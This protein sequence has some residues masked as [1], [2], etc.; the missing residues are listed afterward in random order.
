MNQDLVQPI[1][2]GPLGFQGL[3]TSVPRTILFGEG[4]AILGKSSFRFLLLPEPFP[5]ALPLNLSYQTLR[6]KYLYRI[7]VNTCEFTSWLCNFFSAYPLVHLLAICLFLSFEK[8]K[9]KLSRQ[10]YK[11]RREIKNKSKVLS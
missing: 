7:L 11:N 8:K 9:W 1:L 5:P 3:R 6:V 2:Q 4:K 10:I